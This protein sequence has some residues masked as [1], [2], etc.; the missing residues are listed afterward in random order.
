MFAELQFK[1]GGETDI[2]KG[3]LLERAYVDM[4]ALKNLLTVRL[5]YT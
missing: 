3:E 4:M 5:Y 1:I 2:E